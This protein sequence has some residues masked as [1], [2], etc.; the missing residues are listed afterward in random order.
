MRSHII[1]LLAFTLF[2]AV[3]HA[4]SQRGLGRIFRQAGGLLRRTGGS[5]RRA[6]ASVGRKASNALQQIKARIRKYLPEVEATLDELRSRSGEI[7]AMIQSKNENLFKAGGI[8]R[9]ARN[10]LSDGLRLIKNK[11]HKAGLDKML[12]GLGKY[13]HGSAL[14]ER[15]R[16]ATGIFQTSVVGAKKGFRGAFE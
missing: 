13:K 6:G 9:Q 14:A 11:S 16:S 12:D 4:D 8:M 1:F 15:A 2:L 5:V 3:D 7:S 10:L